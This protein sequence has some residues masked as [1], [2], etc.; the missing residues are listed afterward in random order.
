MQ[1]WMGVLIKQE[2]LRQNLSQEGVYRG[3]CAVS[4]LSKIE[5][6]RVEP[7]QDILDGL[8]QALGLRLEQDE[9]FLQTAE[10][11]L[12]GYFDRVLREQTPC[13]AD[14]QALNGWEN[15]LLISRLCLQYRLYQAAVLL[16]A[17]QQERSLERLKELSQFQ[18]DMDEETAFLYWI[19]CHKAAQDHDESLAALQKA[20]AHKICGLGDLFLARKLFLHGDYLEALSAC[21]KGYERGAV[22]GDAYVLEWISYLEG[23]CYANLQNIPLMCKAF[24]RAERLTRDE[25]TRGWIH[26]NIGA[27][28]LQAGDLQEALKHL[29]LAQA[30]IPEEGLFDLYHKLAWTWCGLG[31][32]EEA[33]A[34]LRQM[35]AAAK[36]MGQK[37]EPLRRKII[38]LTHLRLEASYQDNEEYLAL[39]G[40][41]YS[42][43]EEKAH[44]GFK[45]FYAPF[46]IEALAHRRRYKE[47]LMV[48]GKTGCV[49][50]Y[51]YPFKTDK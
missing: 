34:S 9:E 46:Y 22:E 13:E 37:E 51:M 48:A 42:T 35:E 41:L 49:F 40:E 50:S 21:T 47:A 14:M 39:L 6:G 20:S 8:F 19:L 7:G 25:H 32:K 17:G 23:C 3:V 24:L 4:Y 31:N 11:Y 36:W 44:F 10:R 30:S 2:R 45:Q 33:G 1:K 16:Y 12:T 28:Y 27:S 26:Y 43:I 38:R 5:K 29:R 15:R 18:N